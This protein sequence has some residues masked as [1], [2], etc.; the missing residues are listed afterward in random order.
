MDARNKKLQFGDVLLVDDDPASQNLTRTRLEQMGYDVCVVDDGYRA[1]D[2]VQVNRFSVVLLDV[3]MPGIDGFETLRRLRETHSPAELPVI[4]VTARDNTEDVVRA[5][6]AGANDYLT[7]PIE[8]TVADLRIQIQIELCRARDEIIG[9]H[10]R[11]L[12]DLD[13]AARMQRSL[14]PS[15][16]FHNSNIV[17]GWHYQPCQQLGG[18]LLNIFGITDRYIGLYVLDVSGHGIPSALLSVAVSRSLSPHLRQ[19]S[20]VVDLNEHSPVPRVVAPAEVAKRLNSSYR[21]DENNGLFFTLQYGVIDLVERTLRFVSAGHPDPIRVDRS[22][23][24]EF[25]SCGGGP[26]IGVVEDADY[27]DAVIDLRIGDRIV[28]YS[29]GVYEQANGYAEPFGRER[30]RE[31]AAA[32]VGL[33]PADSVLALVDNVGEWCGSRRMKDDVTVLA[34]ELVGK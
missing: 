24:A 6:R 4:M 21:M 2:A 30:L 13:A 29:D 27:E 5:F 7:K 3:E 33:S 11:T 31:Q 23:S 14:L 15:L 28:L 18:D 9:V 25:L 10:E 32:T 34:I 16:Q 1:I 12:R 20:V 19:G 26:P 8:F 17:T 22:G